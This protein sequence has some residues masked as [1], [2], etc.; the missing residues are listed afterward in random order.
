M[1]FK[2]KALVAAVAL[3]AVAGQASAAV[4]LP[5]A[6]TP[7]DAIFFAIDQAAG[8]SFTFDLGAASG[9]AT[10]NQNITGGAFSA[11]LAAE[12]G[13]LANTTWGIVYNQG[14]SSATSLWG[15][16]VTSGSAIGSETPLKM[17]GGRVAFN[18]FLGGTAMTV[19]G[20]SAFTNAANASNFTN[21]MKNSFGGNAAGWTIDNAVGTAADF[22]TVTAATSAAGGTLVVSGITFNGTTVAV[23][24]VPEPETYSMLA[25]GLLMLGAVA[26]RRKA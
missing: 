23:A 24:A 7:S 16:T 17:S 13:S 6:S 21:G 19:A 1:N 10:L 9:L 14:N 22:Y 25:A 12:G 11:Y 8:N 5:T 26:R 4:A 18:N 3:A 15:T 2:L 20:T